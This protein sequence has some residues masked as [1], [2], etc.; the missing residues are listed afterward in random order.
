MAVAP[1]A[2]GIKADRDEGEKVEIREEDNGEGA[3]R[4]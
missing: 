3:S 1:D 4:W 2:S